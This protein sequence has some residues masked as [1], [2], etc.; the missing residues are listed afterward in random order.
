LHIEGAWGII[1]GDIKK[2]L[3]SEIEDNEEG[4][5]WTKLSNVA[6]G[7]MFLTLEDFTRQ[8]VVKFDDPIDVLED[9]FT[10]Y[11]PPLM[12]FNRFLEREKDTMPQFLLDQ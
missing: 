12:T 6:L 5:K 7:W 8:S 11:T 1:C 2:P 4:K 3:A 10:R 9:L